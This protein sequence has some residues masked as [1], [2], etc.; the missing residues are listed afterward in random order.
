MMAH[1]PWMTPDQ[2]LN[3]TPAQALHAWACWQVHEVQ[4]LRAQ[5]V[6]ARMAKY[7]RKNWERTMKDLET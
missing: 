4:A 7:D 1:Y 3:M 2:L 5:A 6:S